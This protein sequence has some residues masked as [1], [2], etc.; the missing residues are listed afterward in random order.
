MSNAVVDTGALGADARVARQWHWWARN[1]PVVLAAVAIAP[2]EVGA[3][4]DAE[5]VVDIVDAV[6]PC[7]WSPVARL[8]ATCTGSYVGG[9]ILVTASHC[10]DTLQ[11]L[12]THPNSPTSI[13]FTDTGFEDDVGF[14]SAAV[15]A[16]VC[17]KHP[18]APEPDIGWCRLSEE[19]PMVARIPVMVPDRCESHW[20]RQQVLAAAP[21]KLQM[22]T[23]GFGWHDEA[24]SER[25][26]KRYTSY[27]FV[28]REATGTGRIPVEW[29]DWDVAIDDPR[30]NGDSGGPNYMR[31]PDGTW[32]LVAVHGGVMAD[33]NLKY[34]VPSY[35]SWI[36]KSSG[37]DITPCHELDET[38]D[39]GVANPPNWGRYV[40]APSDDCAVAHSSDPASDLRGPKRPKSD[41]RSLERGC[42]CGPD[43]ATARNG[44]T[45]AILERA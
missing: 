34:S 8:G 45:M 19:P 7:Q 43:H 36:E 38:P 33:D 10:L 16:E 44:V 40:F 39:P 2:T 35:V 17:R 22:T 1:T 4:L 27:G 32:R 26:R 20:V 25:G 6:R 5:N 41:L 9:R 29:T 13:S 14:F 21:G 15:T 30:A 23:V 31:L 18:D 3:M 11:T 28:G 37:V 12:E 42:G 24:E